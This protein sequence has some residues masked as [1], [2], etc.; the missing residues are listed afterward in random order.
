MKRKK[1][2]SS[3]ENL[4]EYNEFTDKLN[5]DIDYQKVVEALDKQDL[6]S[7]EDKVNDLEEEVKILKATI[8]LMQEA[9]QFASVK[10]NK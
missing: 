2:M 8:A 6:S 1:S 3:D 10:Y 4:I 5:A 7:L 9:M